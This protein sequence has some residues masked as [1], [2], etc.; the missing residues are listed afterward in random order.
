M[1][2]RIELRGL[3]KRF[4]GTTAL[5]G[6]TLDMEGGVFG[7]LAALLNGLEVLEVR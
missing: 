1:E 5:D 7:I 6:V 2:N 3:R 4:G